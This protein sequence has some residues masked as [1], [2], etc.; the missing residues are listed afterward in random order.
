MPN[1]EPEIGDEFTLRLTNYLSHALEH[2]GIPKRRYS[3]S[4][5]GSSESDKGDPPYTL[6]EMDQFLGE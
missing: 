4:S 6:E 1:C 3:D 5:A 2:E